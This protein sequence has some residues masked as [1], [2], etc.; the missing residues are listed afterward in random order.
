MSVSTLRPAGGE[1]RCVGH[2]SNDV[3][4]S[5]AVASHSGSPDSPSS[6]ARA[7]GGRRRAIVG[8]IWRRNGVSLS[9]RAHV[10]LPVLRTG[11]THLAPIRRHRGGL[12]VNPAGVTRLVLRR[13][14]LALPARSTA[15]L[16][17]RPDHPEPAGKFP[18]RS[19]Y[20]RRETG[21]RHLVCSDSSRSGGSLQVEWPGSMGL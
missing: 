17:T 15:G 1:G 3:R 21:A 20:V 6:R 18:A 2:S 7:A 14:A 10:S 8:S 9:Y 12:P 16:L 4:R 13:V 11:G 19:R 5:R